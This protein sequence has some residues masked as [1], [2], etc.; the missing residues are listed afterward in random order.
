MKATQVN[1]ARPGYR[2]G[3]ADQC[4]GSGNDP[5]ARSTLSRLERGLLVKT[6]EKHLP[7]A[8]TNDGDYIP[9]ERMDT[10]FEPFAASSERG[11]G[12]GLWI[13]YQI[14]P[15]L[16]DGKIEVESLPGYTTFKVGIPYGHTV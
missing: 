11:H 16:E 10:L 9:L 4:H 7:L 13:V 15:Q 1:S 14:V 6:T 8:V 3:T 2:A 12:L 5:L